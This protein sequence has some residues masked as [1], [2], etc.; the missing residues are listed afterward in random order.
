MAD[1]RKQKRSRLTPE[2]RRRQILDAARVA[3]AEQP[4]SEVSLS[5]VARE[6]GV[7]RSLL[8]HYFE[9]KIE[10]LVELARDYAVEAPATLRTDLGLPVDEMVEA[11]AWAW[12]DYVERNRAAAMALLGEGPFAQPDALQDLTEEMREGLVDRIALNHFGTSD[13]PETTRLALRAFTG[14]FAVA[15]RDWLIEGRMSREQAHTLLVT[16]LRATVRE[17]APALAAAAPPP[18]GG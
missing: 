12:L 18:T 4:Y 16:A 2:A 5:D 9:G 1:L 6:A 11:N 3:F 8:N 17:L 13:V 7:S 10:L 14:L 15:C